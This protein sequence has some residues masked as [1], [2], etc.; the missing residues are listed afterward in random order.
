LYARNE[1]AVGR[2]AGVGCPVNAAE[3]AAGDARVAR[4]TTH[5]LQALQS[6]TCSTAVDGYTLARVEQDGRALRRAAAA[7]ATARLLYLAED[8]EAAGAAR[9]IRLAQLGG[10]PVPPGPGDAPALDTVP[11]PGFPGAWVL[12][13]DLSM[14]LGTMVGELLEI[15]GCADTDTLVVV[16]TRRYDTD[17]TVEVAFAAPA[18]EADP[19]PYGPVL[20]L[21]FSACMATATAT[22]DVAAAVAL[23]PPEVV[24]AGTGGGAGVAGRGARRL[25]VVPALADAV[26]AQF[27]PEIA[28]GGAGR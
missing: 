19:A 25:R 13:V 18:A 17:G 3:Q 14:P 9:R 22:A 6:H 15:E 11:A 23:V 10:T 4:R 24:L 20:P 7:G 16:A 2:S 1:R 5:H 27:T 8:I 12:R 26:P 21:P 28:A